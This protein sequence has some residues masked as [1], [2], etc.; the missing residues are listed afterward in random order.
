[1]AAPPLGARIG[2]AL[3]L[4][5]AAIKAGAL[6][7]GDMN[8]LHH[9]DAVAAASRFG[10]LIASGAHTSALL[11]GLLG[12]GFA[13]EGQDG[14][15]AV[16]VEYRVQFRAPVRVGRAMQMQ[17][18]VVRLQPRR[19]GTLATMAGSITDVLTGAQAVTAE[20]QVLYFG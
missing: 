7:V 1:M 14:P 15:G 6:M 8:P 13:G 2:R 16:G 18:Q 20:I 4:D 17:W 11:A 10:E 5:A 12:G 19:S 3:C 9:D